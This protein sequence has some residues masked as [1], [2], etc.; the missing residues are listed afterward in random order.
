MDHIAVC[1]FQTVIG[2]VE[3]QPERRGNHR[4]VKGMNG[5]FQIFNGFLFRCKRFL[6][7]VLIIGCLACAC[8][9][10]AAVNGKRQGNGC[11]CIRLDLRIGRQLLILQIVGRFR[12]L[13]AVLRDAVDHSCLNRFR[14]HGY[15]D[16]LICIVSDRRDHFIFSLNRGYRKH[17]G[18]H[19]VKLLFHVLRVIAELFHRSGICR[20]NIGGVIPG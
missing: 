4:I 12:R 17:V 18:C 8:D 7:C 2:G 11:V 16:W 5:A 19:T 9:I 13:I 3:I 6:A 20:Q 10:A 14:Y 1:G 15:R